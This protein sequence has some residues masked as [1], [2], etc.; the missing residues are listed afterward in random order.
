MCCRLT[1][2]L[3]EWNRLIDSVVYLKSYQSSMVERFEENIE[4]LTTVNYLLKKLHDRCLA[5]S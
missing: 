2:V 3:L 4:Q 5:R 1:F